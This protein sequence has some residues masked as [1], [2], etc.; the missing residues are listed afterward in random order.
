MSYTQ[1]QKNKMYRTFLQ[2]FSK[3]MC[4]TDA[5]AHAMIKVFDASSD[6]KFD[7]TS[8]ADICDF[9]QTKLHKQHVSLQKLSLNQ[10]VKRMG[11]EILNEIRFANQRYVPIIKTNT[12]KRYFS[13][14][15][16]QKDNDN[17]CKQIASQLSRLEFLEQR[18][19]LLIEMADFL[20][21][22]TNV[23]SV[24][25]LLSDTRA[26]CQR[27]RVKIAVDKKWLIDKKANAKVYADDILL[28]NARNLLPLSS[29]SPKPRINQR[30]VWRG[31]QAVESEEYYTDA[32]LIL[33]KAGLKKV[34]PSRY[35]GG[36]LASPRICDAIQQ[37]VNQPFLPA[38][39]IGV[40]LPTGGEHIIQIPVALFLDTNNE[41]IVPVNANLLYFV[42]AHSKQPVWANARYAVGNS[43][44]IPTVLQLRTEQCDPYA[45]IACIMYDF[46]VSIEVATQSPIYKSATIVI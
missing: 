8:M 2:H 14:A 41:A 42:C 17:L 37:Q 35:L 31:R 25:Y 18:L 23:S 5:I 21:P 43:K 28:T 22:L 38:K 19:Q 27:N 26:Q 46:S 16:A 36:G 24:L 15:M 7:P 34:F 1:A 9:I 3:T 40:L 39:F 30:R 44:R 6:T 45:M 29:I 4:A 10:I 20:Q 12:K 13:V 11:Q 33:R 32:I